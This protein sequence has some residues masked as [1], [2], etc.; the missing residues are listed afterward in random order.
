MR[1]PYLLVLVPIVLAATSVPVL[2]GAWRAVGAVAGCDDPEAVAAYRLARTTPSEYEAAIS[3]ALADDDAELA[4]STLELARSRD[5]EISPSLSADVERTMEDRGGLDIGSGWDGFLTGD[6]RSEEALAGAV[7]ADMTGFGDIRDLFQQARIYGESGEYDRITV[8]LAAAGLALTVSTYIAIGTGFPARAGVSIVKAARRAGRLSPRLIEHTGSM[9]EHVVDQAAFR[10]I[11]V[12]LRHYAPGDALKIAKSNL[13]RPKVLGEF[14]SLGE[15]IYAV[16]ANTG[17]RGTLQ[18]LEVADDAD[19]I[20]RIARASRTMGTKTRG[21]LALLGAGA[22]SL[23]SVAVSVSLWILSGL[24]WIFVALFWV[25][26]CIRWLLG[27]LWPRR[28][29]A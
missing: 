2:P 29:A 4:A 7:V 12:A 26:G 24:L 11:S 14:R 27:R 17:Y 8:G 25:V 22:F 18:M 5:V 13:V 6:A 10:E 23:A 3:A 16:G 28:T 21:A 9:A 15:N 1:H 19:D 20:R